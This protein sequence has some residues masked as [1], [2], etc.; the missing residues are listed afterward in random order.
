MQE[1]NSVL[2]SGKYTVLYRL[3][4]SLIEVQGSQE[5]SDWN[6]HCPSSPGLPDFGLCYHFLESTKGPVHKTRITY[7]LT[8][9]G[10]LI[11]SLATKTLDTLDK[12]TK[13]EISFAF[14]FLT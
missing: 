9:M 3:D 13:F 6:V 7:V 2:Y 10:N 14:P 5:L 1:I 8:Y 12:L 4:T 11:A